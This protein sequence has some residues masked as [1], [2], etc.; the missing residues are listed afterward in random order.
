MI[1]FSPPRSRRPVLRDTAEVSRATYT[2]G[3]HRTV[4]DS[5][6]VR[7]AANSAGYLMPHLQSGQSLLDIGCGP[8][9]ITADLAALVAPG[10]V[11]AVDASSEVL[12]QAA[13]LFAERGVTVRTLV[14]DAVATALPDDCVDVV[15]AHQVLQH[16]DDP[17]AVLREMR[18]VCRPGGLVAVRDAD[19]AAFTWYPESSA[20]TEW[21]DLYRRVTRSNGGEPDAGRRLRSWA[22]AAGLVDVIATSSTWTYAS[23]E[24]ASWWAK[25]WA[26]RILW[27]PIADQA[28]SG[29][30]ASRSDLE[31]IAEGWLAWGESPDAWFV[32]VHGEILG[33]P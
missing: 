12:D 28:V 7:T 15:H 33:R 24:A 16:V 14:S 4:L 18:R 20:I 1:S 5:Y 30:H 11:I 3:Q 21:R 13:R 26:D 2:H 6:R 23:A 22:R 29:L 32:I 10:E 19:Y 31:D 8:G 9:S 27:S 17:V 25:A